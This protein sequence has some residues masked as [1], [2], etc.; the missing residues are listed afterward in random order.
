MH[1]RAH[2]HWNLY[3]SFNQHQFHLS[4]LEAHTHTF[5]Y[6]LWED[7][8]LSIPL[9]VLMKLYV[10]FPRSEAGAF[11]TLC[12]VGT[13]TSSCA[14]TGEWVYVWGR[15]IAEKPSY[16]FHNSAA[17]SLSCTSG[18][19][20]AALCD[21]HLPVY[22][23]HLDCFSGFVV[24]GVFFHGDR[25]IL[26]PRRILRQPH[27]ESTVHMKPSFFYV[28]GIKQSAQM[29]MQIAAPASQPFV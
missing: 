6:F 26:S 20:T 9:V 4:L 15:L 3:P 29:H 28:R 16:C 5:S 27:S 10:P 7:N 21:I 24:W 19:L 23:S 14:C 22:Y 18:E 1:A 13:P 25:Y 11:P 12:H 17:A 2:T 8:L